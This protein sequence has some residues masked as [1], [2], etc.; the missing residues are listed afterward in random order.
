MKTD[1][2]P[3]P[4]ATIEPTAVV[5]SHRWIDVADADFDRFIELTDPAWNDWEAGAKNYVLGL[6]RS[7][8]APAPAQT[9]IWLMAWYHDLATWDGVTFLEQRR[10]QPRQRRPSDEKAQ[11][12]GTRSRGVDTLA[13]RLAL[14]TR[15]APSLDSP[16]TPEYAPGRL[17]RCGRSPG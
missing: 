16:D 15:S 5:F 6:W 13:A 10:E 12:T 3:A 4:G 11:R 9:R 1:A 2:P 17:A 14:A 8:S 7:H